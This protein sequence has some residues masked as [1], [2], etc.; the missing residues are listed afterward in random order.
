MT[1]AARRPGPAGPPALPR[2]GRGGAPLAGDR[3]A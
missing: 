2:P 3:A 1:G